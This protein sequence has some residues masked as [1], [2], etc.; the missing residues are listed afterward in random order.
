M[1]IL[2]AF[3]IWFFTNLLGTVLLLFVSTEQGS[4]NPEYFFI[5]IAGGIFSLPALVLSALSIHFLSKLPLD[6]A[7]RAA[8][9]VG[10]T[11]AAVSSVLLLLMVITGGISMPVEFLFEVMEFLYPYC[12][13]AIAT[14]F[15]FTRDLIFIPKEEEQ[16]IHIHAISGDEQ[17]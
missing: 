17:E 2:R 7:I 11:S 10:A 16:P 13:M 6:P 15:Y 1:P 5:L 4:L 14:S 8:Y 3:K 9:I 12:I